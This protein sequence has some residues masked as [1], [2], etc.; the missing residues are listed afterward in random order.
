MN[1]ECERIN[2]LKENTVIDVQLR[3]YMLFI[4]LHTVYCTKEHIF[5]KT[6]KCGNN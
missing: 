6:V 5:T 3:N 1:V 4:Y 2:Y